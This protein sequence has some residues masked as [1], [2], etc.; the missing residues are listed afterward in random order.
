MLALEGKI[1]DGI[2]KEIEKDEDYKKFNV[3]LFARYNDTITIAE[4]YK[5]PLGLINM[6]RYVKRSISKADSKKYDLLFTSSVPG[7]SHIW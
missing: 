2:L 4:P 7:I 6:Y 1:D 5:L 3:E